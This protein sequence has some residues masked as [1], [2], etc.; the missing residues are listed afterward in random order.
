MY[1]SSSRKNIFYLLGDLISLVLSFFVA[2]LLK[3]NLNINNALLPFIIIIISLT[4]IA[5]SNTY[6]VFDV[7]SVFQTIKVSFKISM[8]NSSFLIMFLFF[9]IYYNQRIISKNVIEFIVIQFIILFTL[10]FIN[11]RVINNVKRFSDLDRKNIIFFSNSKDD[12]I[13][14]N[15]FSQYG[16]QIIACLTNG[17]QSLQEIPLLR[18]FDELRDFLADNEV[19]EIL[20]SY[21]AREEF[22]SIQNKLYEIGIPVSICL[23]DPTQDNFSSLIL[24]KSGSLITLT[25]SLNYSDFIN[26]FL[27]RVFDIIFS[28]IGLILTFIVALF[29]YPIIQKQSKGPLLFKQ[30]RIGANGKKFQM[31]KFRS[32]YLDAESKK[33]ELMQKNELNTDLMFKIDEDPRIFPFGKIIRSW[34]IDELPQFINVLKGDMSI[35]GTR[36][37]TLEEY[38]KYKLHHFKRLVMKPGITGMWQVSGRSNIKN[39]EKVVEL[40]AF[41]IR[42]WSL[43]LDLKIILKTFKVVLNRSGSK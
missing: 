30:V 29:I 33:K 34:S 10:V 9:I 23:T 21:A 7:E 36:P 25:H 32:M 22:F 42:N 17:E 15:V 4:F 38:K 14:R 43:K 5:F 3:S 35:V 28:I 27:K 26:L 18:N 16:Y 1:S 6:S 24:N 39:F 20:V 31:Y 40:D 19:N 2:I 41:Y 12:V 11:R 13:N 37:P 8:I